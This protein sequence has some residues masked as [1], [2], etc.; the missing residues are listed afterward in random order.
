MRALVAG[1]LFC[2]FSITA[3]PLQTFNTKTLGLRLVKYT[4]TP[5][6]S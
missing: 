4:T 1:E 3:N 6:T 2:K 5:K